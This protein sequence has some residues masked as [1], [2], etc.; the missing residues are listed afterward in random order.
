MAANSLGST[1]CLSFPCS[2]HASFLT[3]FPGFH[4]RIDFFVDL[5]T[6]LSTSD[7]SDLM[8]QSLFLPYGSPEAGLLPCSWGMYLRHPEMQ[9]GRPRAGVVGISVAGYFGPAR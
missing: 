1:V 8:C 9:T 5:P 3:P 4:Y 7:G 6:F 2:F